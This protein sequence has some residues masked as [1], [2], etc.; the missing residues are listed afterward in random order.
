MSG[1]HLSLELRSGVDGVDGCHEDDDS[2]ENI[3]ADQCREYL[4]VRAAAALNE[5]GWSMNAPSPYLMKYR[6]RFRRIRPSL[7]RPGRGQNVDA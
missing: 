3:G 2:K 1:L 4:L 7:G 6:H 5:C